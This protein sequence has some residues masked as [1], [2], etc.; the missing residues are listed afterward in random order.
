MKENSR[1]K[2][3][4]QDLKLQV[5]M[6]AM[7]IWDLRGTKSKEKEADGVGTEDQY[8][9]TNIKKQTE[10]RTPIPLMMWAKMATRDNLR[11]TKEIRI[12]KQNNCGIGHREGVKAY[13]LTEVDG[14]F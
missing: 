5:A 3:R 6:Q 12:G 1:S 14:L 10:T 8:D 13:E 7:K 2:Y 4:T 11:T 9:R